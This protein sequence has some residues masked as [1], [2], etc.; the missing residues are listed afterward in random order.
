M[1][2]TKREKFFDDI[3]ETEEAPFVTDGYTEE[4]DGDGVSLSD[5]VIPDDDYVPELPTVKPM[6]RQG[7]PMLRTE[8][9]IDPYTTLRRRE[10]LTR[11]RCKVSG[12]AFDAAKAS[13]FRRG[14][15]SV[16]P[17]MRPKII[18]DLQDHVA[19]SHNRSEGHIV[20]ESDLP[21]DWYGLNNQGGKKTF[22]E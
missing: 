5:D 3:E 7:R 19:K 21:T 16:P 17:A 6:L 18:Q 13:G 8:T 15:Q 1:K 4:E 12:C 22:N 2:R 9:R 20:F 10:P 14:Y 11:S